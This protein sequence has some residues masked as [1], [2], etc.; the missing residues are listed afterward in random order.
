ML[1]LEPESNATEDSESFHE[2]LV[3]FRKAAC[4]L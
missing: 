4:P 2:S 3:I 1:K